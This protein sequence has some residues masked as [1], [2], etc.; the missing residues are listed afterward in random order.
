MKYLFF[1]V[2]CANCQNGE[3]KICSFGYVLT[4]ESFKVLKKKDILVDPAAKFMLGNARVGKGIKLAY[5]LFK[6][7]RA[8]TF[9]HYYKEIKNLLEDEDTLCFGFAVFQDVSYISYSCRRYGLPIIDF[10]F[11]DIQRFEK[12]LNQRNNFSGLDSLIE[13]Y[14]LTSYTYHRSDDDAM[15]TMEVFRELLKRSK[16]GMEELLKKYKDCMDDSIHFQEEEILRKKQKEI[17][18]QHAKKTEMFFAPPHARFDINLYNPN[19]YQKVFFLDPEVVFLYIDDLLKQKEI[20]EKHGII[21]T[22]NPCICQIV[23]VKDL[24]HHTNLAEFHKDV[25]FMEYESFKK[26]LSR[27]TN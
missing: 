19:L 25:I 23:I 15:M 27:K 7:Q 26:E 8:F 20:M 22:K 24:K 3:G 1:D 21:L 17:K 12:K 2:E 10:S 18:R 6:F 11:F 13:E 5:P 14:G 4:D 16:L 9:P